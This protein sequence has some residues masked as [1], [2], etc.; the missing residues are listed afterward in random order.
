MVQATGTSQMT[1]Y[2]CA[3]PDELHPTPPKD[4]AERIL[5]PVAVILTQSWETGKAARDWMQADIVPF[6]K[7]GKR[8][9]QGILKK[10]RKQIIKKSICFWRRNG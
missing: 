9:T 8:R 1:E 6:F 10:L 3:E 5:E 4:P 7:T 2:K